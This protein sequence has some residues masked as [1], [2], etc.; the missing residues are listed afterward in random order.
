MPKAASV[1]TKQVQMHV[2]NTALH[3]SHTCARILT[4]THMLEADSVLT[5][6]IQMHVR[7]TAHTHTHI[8]PHTHNT[9]TCT[10]A[11][12]HAYLQANVGSTGSVRVAGCWQRC[13]EPH[14]SR[15]RD[16]QYSHASL[17]SS[18]WGHGVVEVIGCNASSDQASCEILMQACHQMSGRVVWLRSLGGVHQIDNVIHRTCV[19][20]VPHRHQ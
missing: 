8:R 20:T 12:M 6:Q 19:C 2:R 16:L 7:N 11:H 13:E 1:L 14:P 18:E 9:H 5:K 4:H 3:I 17:S 10:Q 15:H